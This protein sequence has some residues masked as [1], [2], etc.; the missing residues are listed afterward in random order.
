MRACVLIPYRDRLDHLNI[1]IPSIRDI[2]PNALIIVAEQFDNLP[3]K[4][5]NLLNIAYL[6][7]EDKADYFI[8][9]DVD[10][11]PVKGL[12]DYSY[13]DTPLHIATQ[14]SQFNYTMCYADYFGGVNIFTK[15]QFRAVNGFVNSLR[16]W[17]GEDDILRNSF[18][19][20]G[21]T[22]DR[23]Q[24]RFESLPHEKKINPSDYHH[25]LSIYRQKRDFSDGLD[26]CKY[27]LDSIEEK[28]GY[29]LI[30]VKL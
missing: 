29:I 17:G 3:F 25:N 6:Y 9:H 18:I 10:M 27:I 5:G 1:L 30:K 14:C 23:R 7:A 2:I 8:F 22:I 12:V 24:C 28:E 11:I 16:G 26:S 21:F 15:E 20:K 13:S 4:R 19:E